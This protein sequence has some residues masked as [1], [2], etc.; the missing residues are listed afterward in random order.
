MLFVC[1]SKAGIANYSLVPGEILIH[2]WTSNTTWQ[3]ITIK[4]RARDCPVL[5]SYLPSAVYQ[6]QSKKTS[7][8]LRNIERYVIKKLFLTAYSAPFIVRGTP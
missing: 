1:Q 5:V 3:N 4:D 7:G 6:R 2:S 8:N